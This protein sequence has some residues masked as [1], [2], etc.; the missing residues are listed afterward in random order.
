[1]NGRPSAI[2]LHNG[3]IVEL[4]KTNKF[5]LDVVFQSCNPNIQDAEAGDQ[6]EFKDTMGE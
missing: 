1:M 2:L 5:L 6:R 3:I 4:L